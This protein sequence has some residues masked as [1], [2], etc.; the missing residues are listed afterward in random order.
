MSDLAIRVEAIS[1]QYKIGAAKVRHDTLRDQ[2]VDGFFSLIHR[3]RKN[4]HISAG[5][6]AFWALNNISLEITKGEVVGLIG[7]NGAGINTLLKVKRL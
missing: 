4:P 3:K 1:K 7:R 2:M 5:K 6:G